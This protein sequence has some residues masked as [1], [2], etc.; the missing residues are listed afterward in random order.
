MI[1]EYDRSSQFYY[2][3]QFAFS[4]LSP[5]ADSLAELEDVFDYHFY[6]NKTVRDYY[7]P[8]KARIED[9]YQMDS[10]SL[11]LQN[12]PLPPRVTGSDRLQLQS[13]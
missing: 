10:A 2:I 4:Y 3:N 7:K 8:L 5:D 11:L 6:M 9:R 13:A 12:D 1:D